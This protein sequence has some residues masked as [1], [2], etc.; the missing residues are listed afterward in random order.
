MFRR[1]FLWCTVTSYDFLFDAE[2]C[3]KF[4]GITQKLET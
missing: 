3:L 1:S 4:F 2:K